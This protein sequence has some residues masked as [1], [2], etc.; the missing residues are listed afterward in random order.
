MTSAEAMVDEGGG[1]NMCKVA[2]LLKRR[3]GMPVEE[4]QEY[5][6]TS[7]G[8]LVAGCPEVRR[9]V[10]S[11]PLLQ[12]YRKG[13]LLFDGVSEIWFDSAEA[14]DA[15]RKGPGAEERS[16]DAAN[17]LDRARTVWM[18][19]DVYVVKDGTIPDGAV[20]NI[21]FV[22]RRPGMDVKPF[23]RHWLGV[24]GPI[25]SRI[26]SVR[27]YEQNHLNPGEYGA[28]G[29]PPYGGLAVTWFASTADMRQ[30]TTTPE[31]AITRA[32][33]PHFLPDDPLPI[34]ITREH[35]LVDRHERR[36]M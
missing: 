3:P 14:F 25:A 32:D 34:L 15:F 2:V 11:H 16:S 19:V 12:G 13:E 21:E 36:R 24:H 30:G 9:Y 35:V 26:P 31:Y 5:W 18:P 7:H 1:A 28:G 4:F 17:F 6:R 10:Q 23:V 27:R 22:N 29:E 33:E 20:K 8:P